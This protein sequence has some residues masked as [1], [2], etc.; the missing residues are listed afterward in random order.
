MTASSALSLPAALPD[1]PD[2]GRARA[3][4]GQGAD[5]ALLDEADEWAAFSRPVAAAAGEGARLWESSVAFEGMYCAACAGTIE[6]ALRAVPGVRDA[7]VSAA[8][9]RGRV[10][11]DESATRPSAWMQAALAAGYRPVPAHEEVLWRVLVR[12]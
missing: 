12:G 3:R 5:F 9:H 11:W 4:A 6:D 7:Q 10:V 1:A 8:S 2:A